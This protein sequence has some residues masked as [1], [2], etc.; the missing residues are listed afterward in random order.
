MTTKFTSICKA[1]IFPTAKG[2]PGA[3]VTWCFVTMQADITDV[4]TVILNKV[5]TEEMN[6]EDSK[7]YCRCVGT[8]DLPHLNPCGQRWWVV[9]F[10][11]GS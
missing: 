5:G 6:N 11:L 1:R 7:P 4:M 2:I 10:S 3:A 9:V 8:P